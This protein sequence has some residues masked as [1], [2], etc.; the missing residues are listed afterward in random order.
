M[1]IPCSKISTESLIHRLSRS[2]LTAA[3]C[4]IAVVIELVVRINLSI[5]NE[6]IRVT[7]KVRK[8]EPE[9]SCKSAWRD[10]S[11]QGM[12]G[13]WSNTETINEDTGP[14]YDQHINIA[15]I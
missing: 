13:L 3:C 9:L 1:T 2:S 12:S 11:E 14:S 8:E 5:E 7:S 4:E 15:G 6:L 10:T